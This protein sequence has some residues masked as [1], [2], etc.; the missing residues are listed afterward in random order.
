M[1]IMTRPNSENL[2]GIVDMGR[3]A[4]SHPHHIPSL[5]HHTPSNG[6]RFSITDLTPPTQRILPTVFLSRAAISLYDAQY[7][8]SGT[9]IP[10]PPTTITAVT[11]ALRR[12][13][14]TCTDFNVPDSNIRII[15]TEA[16]RVALNSAEYCAAIKDAVG[17]T[18]EMLPKAEEGRVGAMGIASSFTTVEGLVMDLGGGSTQ[19]SWVSRVGGEVEISDAG[20]VSL[21]YGAA[22]ILRRL[23]E[24]QKQGQSAV[25]ALAQ[26]MQT[27][28][29]NAFAQV[30]ASAH[31]SSKRDHPFSLYLSGGGFRG[32]GSVLMDSHA[33][34]PYPVPIINGFGVP[35]STFRNAA[36]VELHVQTSTA[37]GDNI[38]RVSDRRASQIPAVTFLITCL[39][40]A[41]PAIGSVRFCQG[42]VREGALF[43]SLP[44]EVRAEVPLTVATSRFSPD[45]AAAAKALKLLTAA[46]PSLQP[47]ISIPSFAPPDLIRAILPA[48]ANLL[49][50]FAAMPKDQCTV[51][52]LRSTTSGILAGAHG[53]LHEE[54]AGLAVAL[55]EQNGGASGLPQADK[56]FYDSLVRVLSPS[57]AWWAMFVGRIGAVVGV[58]WPAGVGEGRLSVET[59][60]SREGVEVVLGV[61]DDTVTEDKE[62]CLEK[63]GKKKNWIG[64]KER[65]GVKIVVTMTALKA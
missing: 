1:S 48:F 52:A 63:L 60:W 41:L 42:G 26:E 28:F 59:R 46:L 27:N 49:N 45:P 40:A 9:K 36:A 54:R 7:D 20:A 4:P 25:D 18:V 12:F 38:F 16:T 53:L 43:G 2:H 61:G 17:W 64:G 58:V 56:Q 62:K 29:R 37:E 65:F 35:A 8:A 50:E 30:T 57:E 39:T 32:Y 51:A 6:I 55:C 34:S 11:S 47:S 21:P 33:I 10:I 15:A 19:M 14:R 31:T 13:K 23:G 24:A 5:A 44:P 3:Y 22:A